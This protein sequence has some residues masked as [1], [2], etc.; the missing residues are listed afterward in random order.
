MGSVMPLLALKDDLQKE[1]AEFLW[2]GT[3][4]GPEKEVVKKA[5]IEFKSVS[6]G[7]L[8]RYLSWKNFIDPFLFIV[9]FFQ[10]IFIILK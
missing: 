7:K 1:N 4:K 3:K 5:G 8:R 10:S 6:S 9:G 2:V